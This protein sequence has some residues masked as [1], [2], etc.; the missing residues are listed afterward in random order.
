[1]IRILITALTILTSINAYAEVY[2]VPA[3][4]FLIPGH[5]GNRW[6]SELYLTNSSSEEITVTLGGLL[7]GRRRPPEP[8]LTIV[9]V[10]RKVPAHTT[11]LWSAAELGPDIGCASLAL[12]G[13]MFD[14]TAPIDI[15]SR[16]VNHGVNPPRPSLPLHGPGQVVD[17]I[18]VAE[19]PRDGAYLLP[20][21]L[22][23]RNACVPEEFVT[24]LGFAN[25]GDDPVYLTLNLP[26]SLAE[27]GMRIAGEPVELP[28]EIEVPAGSWA[29][30]RPAQDSRTV[31]PIERR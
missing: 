4:A 29:I 8:C 18:A 27:L 17:A 24:Y 3:V 14:A 12:G 22:W 16:L 10:T 21:L 1:M 11:V 15:S 2:L 5:D 6:S 20:G 26:P 23:H 9:P 30:D 31:I 19:L 7:L 25:P 28:H 13:L